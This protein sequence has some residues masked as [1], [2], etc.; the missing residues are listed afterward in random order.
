MVLTGQFG[1]SGPRNSC[2]LLSISPPNAVLPSLGSP[3]M[4]NP[5]GVILVLA[6]I[7]TRAFLATSRLVGVATELFPIAS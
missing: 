1:P 6:L 3:V 4:I 5:F 2:L 7:K